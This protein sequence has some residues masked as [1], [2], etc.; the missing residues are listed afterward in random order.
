[1]LMWN[2]TGAMD[3]DH[4]LSSIDQQMERIVAEAEA[5]AATVRANLE[6]AKRTREEMLSAAH[7]ECDEL[8]LQAE[9]FAA[10]TREEAERHRIKTEAT[11]E[12]QLQEARLEAEEIRAQAVADAAETRT[13]A[14][15]IQALLDRQLPA[16]NELQTELEPLLKDAAMPVTP[17]SWE[18]L[19]EPAPLTPPIPQSERFLHPSADHSIEV[20]APPPVLHVV[21][22][23][24]LTE[25]IAVTE[26]VG[27]EEAAGDLEYGIDL[28]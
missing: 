7:S 5:A 12:D 24:A 11:A 20:P 18:T 9:A 28:A 22:P 19:V 25:P 13:R 21:E 8:R 1:M 3:A 27:L 16:L 6:D 17:P 14:E 23:V 26:S 2:E 4:E 15:A 10:E